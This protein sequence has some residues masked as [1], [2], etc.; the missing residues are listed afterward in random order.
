MDA[1]R[2][3]RGINQDLHGTADID[4]LPVRQRIAWIA[5]IWLVGVGALALVS[6]AIGRLLA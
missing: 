4:L 3:G 6:W 5:A 1:T 2:S